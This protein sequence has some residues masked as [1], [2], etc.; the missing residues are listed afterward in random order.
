MIQGSGAIR[1]GLCCQFAN[2]PIKFR[3]TTVTA[4][5]RLS[6]EASLAKLADLCSVNA[7]ALLDALKW[8]HAN[9]IGC[10]RVNSQILP[11]KTHPEQGYRMEELPGCDDIISKFKACGEFV[12]Q[13]GMRT[14]FHPDQFVVPGSPDERIVANSIA[15]LEYQAEVAEWIRADVLNIHGGGAYGDKSVALARFEQNLER[16]SDRVR[17]RLTLENDDRTYTP[18]D[19]LP[20]CRRAGIPLVYDAHHHRCAGDGLSIEEATTLAVGTW[21]REPMFHISSPIEGWNGPRP[22]RHHDYIA[23]EDFPN[24]WRGMNLTV[25]VEAKAKELAVLR[26]MKDLTLV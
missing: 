5:A 14:C 9:G 21:N 25:E 17:T 3:T 24:C 13:N 7:E 18:E 6:R 15:E 12:N 1:F 16:M 26:L 4:S 23:V 19:L 8:C 22:E 2:V 10:F 11:I 20:I